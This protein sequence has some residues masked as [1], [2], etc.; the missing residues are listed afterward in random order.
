MYIYLYNYIIQFNWTIQFNLIRLNSTIQS[1][2]NR[3]GKRSAQQ[4]QSYAPVCDTRQC[5]TRAS[6]LRQSDNTAARSSLCSAA[7]IELNRRS[8]MNH[9][10][11]MN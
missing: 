8:E 10:I 2:L 5:L 1:N 3:I 9:R 4:F 6:V 7:R 11:E